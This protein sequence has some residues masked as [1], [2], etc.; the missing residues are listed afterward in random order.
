M[1]VMLFGAPSRVTL[2]V[3][4]C[5]Q[6]VRCA[7]I[8]SASK[9]EACVADG[10][11][12]IF[13]HEEDR[14]AACLPARWC[15]DPQCMFGP[16]MQTSTGVNTTLACQQKM[17]ITLSVD[18]GDT[19]ATQQLQ[20]GMACIGRCEVTTGPLATSV[21]WNLPQNKLAW[22]RTTGMPHIVRTIIL[23]PASH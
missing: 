19:L 3:L 12:V 11:Q 8:I 21:H 14:C 18:S 17:I 7:D 1:C 20:L 16:C 10:A 22:Q 23:I 2:L 6:L 4:L 9:L 13:L 15:Q 5:V